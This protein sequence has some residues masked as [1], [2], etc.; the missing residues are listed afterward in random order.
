VPVGAGDARRALLVLERWEGR[1]PDDLLED[2]LAAVTELLGQVLARDEATAQA[3][4]LKEEFLAS[5]SHEF[6]T[7]LTAIRGFVELLLR[8]GP[9]PLTERQRRYLEFVDSAGVRLGRLVDDL[10]LVAQVDAGR[11]TIAPGAAD[12]PALVHACVELLQPMADER[13]IDL[14]ATAS[15][16]EPIEGD[17]IRLAQLLDN[18]VSNA[19]KFTP[20]G[21]RVVVRV[22]AEEDLALI[23][24]ADTG[25]GIPV[26][27][28]STLFERFAR[29]AAA[30]ERGIEGTGLGLVLARAVAE[31]HGGGVTFA[32]AEGEGTTFRVWLPRRAPGPA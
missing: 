18:L 25:M 29:T 9:G 5:V 15:A 22:R 27:E 10:L 30:A 8:E 20:A 7:P 31:A 17:S 1:Q 16:L 23:E 4:R 12:L 2:M 32:S 6:R 13:R 26:A 3:D 11:F 14:Q 19:I 28:Q 24:V 21:G